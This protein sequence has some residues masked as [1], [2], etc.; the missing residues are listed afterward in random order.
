[1]P[2]LII[3]LVGR[4]G[5]G[6]GTVAKILQERYGAEIFRFSAILN[7]ILKRLA[8]DQ[9]RDNLIKLSESLRH[10]YGDDVLAYAIER[11]AATS[12]ADVVVVDGI[13][14]IGDVTALKPLPHFKLVE[15][16]ALAQVRFDR[17]K[18]RGEK[19]GERGM[20][21]EEF[22][23]QELAP[24]ETSIPSVA[25]HAWKAIDNGGTTDNLIDTLDEMMAEL[26]IEK[27]IL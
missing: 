16:S 18:G 12:S 10:T 25:A 14:R 13:R 3:G 15:I 2:K 20:S 8:L 7:D 23:E 27:H 21:W 19:T 22:T 6:K 11:D 9:S 4:Q 26:G 17:M 1:M 24:T 5:S